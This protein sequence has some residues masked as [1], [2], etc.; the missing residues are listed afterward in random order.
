MTASRNVFD[1]PAVRPIPVAPASRGE[2]MRHAPPPVLRP[3]L[4]ALALAV[5]TVSEG[6]GADEDWYT[7]EL[8]VF[9]RIDDAHLH[10]ELWPAAPGR[11]PIGESIELADAAELALGGDVEEGRK[12]GA[13]YAFRLL[14]SSEHRLNH[15]FRRLRRARDY[16]PLLHLA[17]H[18]PGLPKH[19]AMHAHVQGW[20]ET[21]GGTGIDPFTAPAKPVIDGTVQVYRGKFLHLRAD[22]LYYRDNSRNLSRPAAPASVPARTGLLPAPPRLGETQP[23]PE[24]EGDDTGT[25][26]DGYH[27]GK[28]PPALF[29]MHASRRM[30]SGE[31]HYLDH[32][33]FG[34]LALVT[35]YVPPAAEETEAPVEVPEA[36][37]AAAPA[38]TAA[39]A[40]ESAAPGAGE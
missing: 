18:Q 25:D 11:P 1:P 9:E 26:R 37:E 36:V 31:L 24:G 16:R 7:V 2:G 28:E 40:G 14:D 19:R 10:D 35:P 23:A 8:I 17:W 13:P 34:L 33:L 21:E 5:G 3:I 4:V 6:R 27:T 30:R 29:R 39:P 22:L 38:E 12:A 20:Q 32:P 15:V